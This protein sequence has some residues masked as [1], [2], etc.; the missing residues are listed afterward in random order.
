[1]LV[2]V[3]PDGAITIAGR[4]DLSAAI[5]PQ[6]RRVGAALAAASE[7]PARIAGR[8]ELGRLESGST[9]DIVVLDDRL[10]IVRVLVRGD[11]AS[12]D[13]SPG[14]RASDN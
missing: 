4:P 13:R 3:R 10:E 8:T 14:R 1:M 9:A 12:A 6:A 2:S 7:V 11:D 5:G